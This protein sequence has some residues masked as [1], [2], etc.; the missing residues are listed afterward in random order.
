MFNLLNIQR[1]KCDGCNKKKTIG[2]FSF[3]SDAG[4]VF[5]CPQC[6]DN[7][8]LAITKKAD[9]ITF[10]W[11][12]NKFKNIYQEDIKIWEGLFKELDVIWFIENEIPEWMFKNRTRKITKKSDYRKFITN[13][14]KREQMKAI[15]VI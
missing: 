11:E 3:G 6:L 7:A 10:N 12:T 9:K 1:G 13:W 8:S 14:L 15:G 4:E 5:I 2:V